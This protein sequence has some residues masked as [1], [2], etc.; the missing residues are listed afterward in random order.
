MNP[1]NDGLD[2]RRLRY[3][4]QVM[5]N[6]SVRGAAESLGMD[7]SAVSRA[8]GALE[9]DCGLALLERR[10]R[11]VVPS[12]AGRLLADYAQQQSAQ[13]QRLLAQFASIQKV[14]RGHVDLIAGEGF[15]DW[16]MHLGLRRFMTAHPGIT[17]DLTVG[18]TEDIVRAVAEER[19][20]IGLAFQPP[21]DE[22]LR[23]H[24]A[25][26]HPIQAL[27]PATHPLARLDRPL[28]LADL[29]PYPGAALHHAYGVRQHVEAAEISEGVRLNIVFTT[30][31]FKALNHFVAA[32]LGYALSSVPPEAAAG[33]PVVAL[34]LRNPLLSQGSVV[35]VS[36]EGR[37]LPLAAATL[38]KVIVQD[39]E[40]V[41]AP[42]G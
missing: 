2:L 26:P 4:M 29:L 21:Q 25:H 27:V 37:A 39:M 22:R 28:E 8:I 7:P 18:S 30:S 6:G 42:A 9:A 40:A 20:Q 33:A 12:D 41:A 31:S 19:A 36:R 3:F 11:G 24:H 5:E 14:E 16:L 10:G 17:V 35:A 23:L 34:P 32:G 38:L 1:P 15:V 13:Q